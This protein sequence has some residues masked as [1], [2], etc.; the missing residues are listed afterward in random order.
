MG[1][2]LDEESLID[3][4]SSNIDSGDP[5]ARQKARAMADILVHLA[6]I[7]S[8]EDQEEG[9]EG[10]GRDGGENENVEGEPEESKGSVLVDKCCGPI[11]RL[12]RG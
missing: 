4:V 7:G 2:A 6:T 10:K 8:G 11:S 9:E 1:N 3:A 5:D 12:P